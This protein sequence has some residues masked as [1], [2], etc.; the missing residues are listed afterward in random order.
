[1]RPPLFSILGLVLGVGVVAAAPTQQAPSKNTVQQTGW[2]PVSSV[3]GATCRG[4]LEGDPCTPAQK[5]SCKTQVEEVLE[6]H[7]NANGSTPKIPM[8]KLGAHEIP[9]DL[10]QGKYF[11]YNKAPSTF[12]SIAWPKGKVQAVPVDRLGK[13]SVADAKKFHRQPQ[14]DANGQKI[15]T[16]DEYAYEEQ[17]DVMRFLDA[18]NACRGDRSC[19]MDVAYLPSTPGIADRTLK[20]KDGTPLTTF[21]PFPLQLKPAGGTLPKNEM[22]Q[23]G[24]AYL[25]ANGKGPELPRDPELEAW[26]REGQTLYHLGSDGEWDWHAQMRERTKDVSDAEREEYEVRLAKFRELTAQ[27]YAAVAAFE[28]KIGELTAPKEHEIVLPYDMQTADIFERYDRVRQMREHVQKVRTRL[29]KG[30]KKG[31]IPKSIT[32]PAT[33]Q[34]H[35]QGGGIHQQHVQQHAARTAI[36]PIG[37]LGSP[38]PATAGTGGAEVGWWAGRSCESQHGR[39][40]RE[41]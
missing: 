19:I 12:T 10:R 15:A 16:C 22:F 30:I 17:Y 25:Y 13:V 20:R 8:M 14:W 28:N 35:H 11:K 38:P 41:E 4:C 21:G 24:S 33:P 5:A 37:M 6:D 9:R 7:W 26:L 1:M 29:E 27:H 36:Q 3:V 32:Q 39:T 34:Q 31:T 40:R 18:A 23:F 2:P